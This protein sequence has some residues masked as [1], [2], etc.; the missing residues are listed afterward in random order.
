MPE[1]DVGPAHF[2]GLYSKEKLPRGKRRNRPL[3]YLQGNA[4]AMHENSP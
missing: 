2:A 4:R 1:V 3:D